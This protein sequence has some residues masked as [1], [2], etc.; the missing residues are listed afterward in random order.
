MRTHTLTNHNAV[1]STFEEALLFRIRAEFAEMPGLK[2]TLRQA[3][4]LF[5]TEAA[6][7]ERA[8]TSLVGMGQLARRGDS[9][10]QPT[11]A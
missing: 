2:I 10:V 9:F 6:Q 7:C 3:S 1:R 5:H 11:S 8:L 4:R